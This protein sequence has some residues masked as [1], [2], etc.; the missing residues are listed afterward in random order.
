MNNEYILVTGGAGY[1]GSHVVRQLT[2]AGYPV[3]VL[4]N[5]STGHRWAVKNAHLVVGDVGNFSVLETV[6]DSYTIGRVLHFAASIIAPESIFQPLHY[7]RNNTANLLALLEVMQK[8]RV[9][10]LIFSSTA[11]VYGNAQ[12]VPVPETALINPVS[13]YGM[14]KAMSERIIQDYALISPLKFVIL[15]YFNVAGASMDGSLGQVCENASHLIRVG[16]DVATRQRESVTIFG[17]DYSTK[18]GTGL[19]DYIHVEDL[20][21]AHVTALEYLEKTEKSQIF[22]CGYGHG[23]TVKEVLATIQE[24][25]GVTLPTKEGGRRPGDVGE[26][27]ADTR[28]IHEML[29][30]HPKFNN[31]R[32]IVKSAYEW[33]KQVISSS[34][35]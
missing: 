9:N 17:T 4:D 6:F 15:R 20:A 26:M 2:S 5:L 34:L 14:S 22:N 35:I 1:I 24:V 18:D 3:V 23:Y 30:W 28:K 13:P 8:H 10:S 27:V 25:S 21:S 32:T 16:I 7:Y 29:G 19:R 33:Q 12:T 31:L 11:A